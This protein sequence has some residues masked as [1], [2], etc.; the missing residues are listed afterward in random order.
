MPK[1]EVSDQSFPLPLLILKNARV[2][3]KKSR[4]ES[5]K[6]KSEPKFKKW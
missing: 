3:K 2:S 6:K 4:C 1:A 5:E